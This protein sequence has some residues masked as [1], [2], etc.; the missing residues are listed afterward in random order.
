MSLLF[1]IVVAP[2]KFLLFVVSLLGF[3][4]LCQ[5]CGKLSRN[6]LHSEKQALTEVL[7]CFLLLQ[8]DRQI[9]RHRCPV[10][11]L[12]DAHEWMAELAQAESSW[13]QR[14]ALAVRY[15]WAY[16]VLRRILS[17]G[18]HTKG[19]HVCASPHCC[20]QSISSK[21][22][23]ET[24]DSHS[25]LME[26]SDSVQ[27]FTCRT[28]TPVQSEHGSESYTPVNMPAQAD[29]EQGIVAYAITTRGCWRREDSVRWQL[30]GTSWVKTTIFLYLSCF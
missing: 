8:T 29:T 6:M 12:F 10:S 5:L 3:K 23:C 17:L 22:A 1:C 16:K 25:A 4:C 11:P 21:T 20:V 7:G 24:L 9:D 2:V 14:R 27:M 28:L 30:D 19:V 26:A 15:M 18:A 13:G